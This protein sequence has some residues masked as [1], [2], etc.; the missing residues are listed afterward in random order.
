MSPTKPEESPQNKATD[1]PKTEVA[2]RKDIWKGV[3]PQNKSPIK[4]KAYE[5]ETL[6]QEPVES[7]RRPKFFRRH[8]NPKYPYK[9]VYKNKKYHIIHENRSQLSEMTVLLNE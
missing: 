3:I 8:L 6:P 1:R 2:Q 4:L 5:N 9:P 7:N